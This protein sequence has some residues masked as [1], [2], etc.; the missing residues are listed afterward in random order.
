MDNKTIIYISGEGRSGSTL[1]DILLGS[2][3]KSFSAGELINLP[4]KGIVNKEFCSCGKPVPECEIWSNIIK[5]WEEKRILNLKRYIQLQK[6]LTSNR[7]IYSSYKLLKK[8]SGEISSFINDTQLLYDIIFKHTKS[9]IIVDSSKAPGN[10]LI[11]KNMSRDVTIVHLTRRFGDVLNSYKKRLKQDLKA[12]IEHDIMPK[13]TWYIITSWM[14]KNFLTFLFSRGMNYRK[15]KYEQIVSDPSKYFNRL[16]NY[17]PEY[18]STLNQRGPF[19]PRHLVA[20]NK[21][22]MKKHINIAEQPMDTSYHRLGKAAKL[23]AR[24]VDFFY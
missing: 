14:L 20:G 7:N 19:F 18:D 1:L 15:I 12:G 6:K 4:Q 2:Q 9:N 24:S 5:D 3:G 8:P 10:I 21:I 13:K 16:V 17:D 11:L 23:L 22:R